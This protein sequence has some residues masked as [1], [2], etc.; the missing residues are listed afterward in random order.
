MCYL[1]PH[2]ILFRDSELEIRIRNNRNDLIEVVSGL[3]PQFF[4]NSAMEAC[5]VV[6]RKRK[7]AMRKR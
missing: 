7:P 1:L 5:V 2:G 4:Y 6:C 3:G